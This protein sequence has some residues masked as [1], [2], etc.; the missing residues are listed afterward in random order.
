MA[1]KRRPPPMWRAQTDGG[2][3]MGRRHRRTS[4]SRCRGSRRRPRNLSAAL[5]P[6]HCVDAFP[7]LLAAHQSRLIRE[8]LLSSMRVRDLQEAFIEATA[9][10]N[11]A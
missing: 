10:Q 3:T 11:C 7:T 8:T 9:L 4:P 5:P 2:L 6:A 1:R